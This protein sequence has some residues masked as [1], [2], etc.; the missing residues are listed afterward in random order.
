MVRDAKTGELVETS[1]TDALQVAAEGL[2]KARAGK[3]A[4]VLAGGR[5][6]VEDAYA[7]AK[8][9]RIAL[10]TNDVDFR[11]RPHSVEELDFLASTVVGTSPD[12]GGVTYADLESAPAVLCAAFEPEEESPI[13]FLR[14]RKA[15]RKNRTKVFHIGQWTTPAVEKTS[16]T[17]LACA[18]GGEAAAVDA[19]S[20]H[21]PDV[22]E[23]L[24]AAGAVILVG[25]RAAQ[26]VGLLSSLVK[27]AAAT[28]AKLAWIPRRAGERGALDAGAVPNLLPGGRLV[29]DAAARAEVERSWGLAEGTLPATTGRGTGEILTAAARGD[30]DALV[31]GGVDTGDL[32]DPALAEHALATAKFVVSIELRHSSVTQHADVVLPIA[33]TVE[34][35]GSFLNWEGRRREFGA[36]LESVGTLPDCRVLDTLAVEMDADLFTQTPAASAADLARL[37]PVARTAAAPTVVAPQVSP[38]HSDSQVLLATWRHLLDEGS[39][40]EGEPHLAGTA[41]RAVAR[42]SAQTAKALGVEDAAAVTVRT[43]NGAI[44]VPVEL[45]DLPDGVVWLPSNS[46]GSTVRRTLGAGHGDVVTVGSEEA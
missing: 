8:F 11:A 30:L 32:A 1:W 2:T 43:D 24:G 38:P 16:G 34:K 20:T 13:V 10:H 44:T 9:A 45:A 18:P 37:A 41:R 29:T 31:V 46:A 40:Q 33:P 6:T 22:T 28:G 19:L 3:G 17:L 5:V 7:Y 35:A 27:L 26:S 36:T 25:E 15:A 21:A 14:L 23:A 39:L 42:L 4:A 12:N